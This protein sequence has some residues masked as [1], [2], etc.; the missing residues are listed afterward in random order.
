[1][2]VRD[3]LKRLGAATTIVSL[4]ILWLISV[5]LW[6]R[7]AWP[8]STIDLIPLTASTV[9]AIFR[10]VVLD[11]SIEQ[12]N[13]LPYR[14][15]AR[16]RVERW[17][18]GERDSDVLVDY[19]TGAGI[20]GHYC[21][22][23]KPGEHWLI[24]GF[25]R[26]GHFELVDDCYAAVVVSPLLAPVQPGRDMLDQMQADF[27]AGLDDPDRAGRLVSIQRL[28]GLKTASSRPALHRQI[29]RGDSAEKNWATYAALRT[30][31]RTVVS[32][33]CEM[34]VRGNKD[35]QPHYLAFELRL[36]ISRGAV[37]DPFYAPDVAPGSSAATAASAAFSAGKR[38]TAALS[39]IAV[40][41]ADVRSEVRFC[42]L[43]AM[44]AI[45]H[46]PARSLIQQPDWTSDMVEP[47]IN[48]CLA[49]WNADGKRRYLRKQ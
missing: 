29:E 7:M 18:R 19:T 15:V 5:K 22:D 23:F 37:P 13:V 34:F 49:W 48:H 33:A 8:P 43:N 30:G 31:D 1:M 12:G 6:S 44:G 17:Y 45:T 46:E 35:V 42:A 4:V 25:E 3:W 9:P 27:T 47:E 20:P 26:N 24:F 21:I 38:P 36:L 39:S 32:K 40:H 16:L 11:V 41:L 14:A 10:G 28:G 2:R